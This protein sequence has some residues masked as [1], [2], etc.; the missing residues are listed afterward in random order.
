MN[1]H[2][3]LKFFVNLAKEVSGRKYPADRNG[4]IPRFLSEAR[5]VRQPPAFG[6]RDAASKIM[7]SHNTWYSH[8]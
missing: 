4:A 5:A 8:P 2:W 1:G 3:Y 7:Y 6:T